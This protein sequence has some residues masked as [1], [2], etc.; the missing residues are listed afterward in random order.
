[1]KDTAGHIQLTVIP[2]YR[3]S[4]ETTNHIVQFGDKTQVQETLADITLK[5]L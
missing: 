5:H 3:E 2:E 1:M 4:C